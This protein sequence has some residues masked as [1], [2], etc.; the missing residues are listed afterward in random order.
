MAISKFNGYNI[1]FPLIC[2][3]ICNGGKSNNNGNY[4][5]NNMY[6]LDVVEKKQIRKINEVKKYAK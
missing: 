5:I 6:T 4:N 3:Y 1:V 2:L